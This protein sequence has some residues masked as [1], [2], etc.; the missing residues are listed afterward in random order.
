MAHIPSGGSDPAATPPEAHADAPGAFPSSGEPTSAGTVIEESLSSPP[1]AV[2]IDGSSP[3]HLAT[4]TNHIG[5]HG[6]GGLAPT[7]PLDQ[8]PD[9]DPTALPD[10]AIHSPSKFEQRN[11]APGIPDRRKS[12]RPGSRKGRGG[13]AA[14]KAGKRLSMADLAAEMRVKD[15]SDGETP[16]SEKEEEGFEDAK[17]ETPRPESKHTANEDQVDQPNDHKGE[18]AA[19]DKHR[20]DS[21]LGID[22]AAD[23]PQSSVEE[24]AHEPEPTVSPSQGADAAHVAP[25]TSS[26]PSNPGAASEPRERS[27][28]P[29]KHMEGLSGD[30]IVD[31]APPP[32][33]AERQH[34]LEQRHVGERPPPPTGPIRK[35]SSGFAGF[36]GRMGSIRK[37]RSPSAPREGGKFSRRNTA[38]SA[39]SASGL[40]NIPDEGESEATPRPGLKEQFETLRRQEEF[41]MSGANGRGLTPEPEN[42]ED[43]AQRTRS[44]ADLPA[45]SS[46]PNILE[47][48]VKTERAHSTSISSP[49]KSPPIM[50]PKLPP[51]TASG[52]TAGAPEEPK[53]VDWDLWQKVVYEGPSA[54][55]KS[56]GEELREAIASGIPPAIRGVVWQVLAESKNEELEQIYR[57]LKARGTDVEKSE[58]SLK[59]APMSRSESQTGL[60]NGTDDKGSD[61]SSRSSMHSVGS[62]ATPAT[63]PPPSVQD[64]S[65][66]V[67]AKLLSEKQKRES[68][69]LQKLEK[70]IRRDLGARTSFSKYTQSAGLQDGLFGVCKAYAL[71]DEGVGYAQGINFIAM[72]LLFNLSEEEA[73]TLLVRLM[74]KYD[75]RSM[76]TPDMSGLHL[77]LYQFE[78]LLEDLEPA[79]YCHLR[80]RH[81]SPQLY[82]TQWF[83]T[84]FAYR[85]PLQLVLRVHDLMLSEGLTAILRFG[86]VLMQRNR[87]ALLGMKDMSSLSTF[88]KERLFDVYIDKSPD[89]KSMLETGFFGSVS[90]GGAEK[91]LYRA[92][93][94][95]RDACAV[96]V[97][98]ELLAGY[99]AE[100]EE[101]LSGEQA[102]AEELESLRTSTTTLTARVRELEAR[103]QAQDSEHVTIASDLVNLKLENDKLLDENEGLKMKVEELRKIADAQPAEVEEKLKEEMERI[104]Q[105]NIEVQNENRSLKEECEEL[106]GQVVEAKM[107]AAQARADHDSVMQKWQNVQA[108]MNG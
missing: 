8:Q 68:A 40:A 6:D 95:V 101:Q 46:R 106:E 42:A 74:S 18:N 105:R 64:Q 67:T 70:T 23:K 48:D 28:S 35:A 39:T 33:T 52:L 77:R 98:D 87:E 9:T 82:A 37:G 51:G 76:F 78:R 27:A 97:S 92:D 104:M 49:L 43:V 1:S 103:T 96:P 34:N 16:L 108:A 19:D 61:T 54:V 63:S 29:T 47:S 79:L 17:E 14:G 59:P 62:H 56:S 21:G 45:H 72:P 85:F 15:N 20:D 90:G 86:I 71:F 32:S 60:P 94:M 66:E 13:Q 30:F 93:E 44:E 80:R 88:L 5:G 83:L 2:N 41:T 55:Q 26:P 4:D 38:T 57:T 7:S 65:A 36:L 91:E 22:G 107:V 102:K 69:A 25:S 24:P 58:Q 84:L 11:Q 10:I 12:L 81:V 73:F 53:P 99:T 89:A 50:D 100:W 3:I 31:A 75:I